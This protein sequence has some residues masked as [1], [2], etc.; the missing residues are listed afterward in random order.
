MDFLPYPDLL[1]VK[2]ANEDVQIERYV[3]AQGNCFSDCLNPEIR[4][5]E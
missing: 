4:S 3:G 5:S 2:I 1:Q